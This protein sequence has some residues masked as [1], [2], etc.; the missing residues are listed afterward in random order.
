[1]EH[2]RVGARWAP[3]SATV[4]TQLSDRP[5]SLYQLYD[6]EGNYLKTGITSNPGGRY[7]QDFMGDEFMDIINVGTRSNMMDLER[8]TVELNPGPLNLERWAGAAR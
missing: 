7:S 1:M 5:T 4:H 8:R 6:L 2:R 3:V